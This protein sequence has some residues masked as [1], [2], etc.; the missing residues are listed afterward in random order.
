MLAVCFRDLCCSVKPG[1]GVLS[2]HGFL[3]LEDS[4]SCF[5][6]RNALLPKT[7]CSCWLGSMRSNGFLQ[8]IFKTC[9]RH[10]RSPAISSVGSSWPNSCNL[11][12]ESW[13]V[14]FSAS[15]TSSKWGWREE[16][17]PINA[18]GP[19]WRKYRHN[20]SQFLMSWVSGI[21]RRP[22]PWPFSFENAIPIKRY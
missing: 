22:D 16:I 15:P 11:C 4:R 9:W 8:R 20:I 17:C 7:K 18:A 12:I 1:A 6:N 10:H 19:S 14:T 2:L 21:V 13:Q 3:R 5:T